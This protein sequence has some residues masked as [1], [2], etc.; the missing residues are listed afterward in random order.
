MIK[1]LILSTLLLSGFLQAQILDAKQL[2][3]KKIT[4][5]VKLESF[6]LLDN[7]F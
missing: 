1:I 6:S 7:Y 5:V 3:N 4:K 2:F